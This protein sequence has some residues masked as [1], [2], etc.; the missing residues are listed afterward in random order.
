MP[1]LEKLYHHDAILSGT[2][3]W[4]FLLPHSFFSSSYRFHVICD[5]I[6]LVSWTKLLF[7]QACLKEIHADL[8]RKHLQ[9]LEQPVSAPTTIEKEIGVEV[10]EEEPTSFP[11]G[12]I[13]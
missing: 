1:E 11:E 10:K 7:L 13:S 12:M 8:L 6:V 4:I 3:S 9:R 5:I 2:D